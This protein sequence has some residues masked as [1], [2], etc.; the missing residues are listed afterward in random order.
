VF[1]PGWEGA[2]TVG[3]PCL[4][5]AVRSRGACVLVDSYATDV[6]AG[7]SSTFC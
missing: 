5:G 6:A 2:V 1:M 7:V 3:T 4:F